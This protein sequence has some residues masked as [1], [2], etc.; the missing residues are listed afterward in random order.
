MSLFEAAVMTLRRDGWIYCVHRQTGKLHDVPVHEYLADSAKWTGK[1][2]SRFLSRP[3][4]CAL[5]RSIKF[6]RN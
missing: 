5:S 3:V 4:A 2:Y 1:T 6:S